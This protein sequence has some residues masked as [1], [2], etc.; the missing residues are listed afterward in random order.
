MK[1]FRKLE[2]A[3]SPPPYPVATVGNFDGLHLGHLAIVRLILQRAE[4][5]HG[6]SI[7]ITFDPHPLKILRGKQC[8][9]LLTTA[10][11]KASLAA[12][13]GVDWFICLEFTEEFSRQRPENFIQTAIVESLGVRELY[14]GYDFHFGRDREGTI[15]T[16]QG[17]AVSQG[18]QLTVVPP[19][20][21]GDVR[22]S[23][24]LI[25]NLII[26]G[27]V[28]EAA[29]YLG[30]YFS[31]EGEVVHGEHRGKQIG[32]ATANLQYTD[33]VMPAEGVYAAYVILDGERRES[34]LNFGRKPTFQGTTVSLE[35]HIFD[36]DQ[37]I[38]GKHLQVQFVD[39]LRAEKTFA[40]A[41]ELI[42]QIN[43]D[44]KR[45]REVF[46]HLR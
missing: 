31:V 39:R 5:N 13:L 24:S 2:E 28:A 35:A 38:Y 27:E 34:V 3:P 14:V 17:L 36:F 4:T 45:A 15:A 19:V 33:E 12:E 46:A 16:L 10:A 6:T 42:T 43:H 25:R 37:D 20:K 7:V 22:V 23:S 29:K 8:P 21:V 9:P 11:Q 41:D 32:F 30:R 1:I 40:S 18:V 44:A 26:E